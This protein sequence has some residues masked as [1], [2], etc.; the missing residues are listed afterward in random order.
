MNR[1]ALLMLTI[2]SIPGIEASHQVSI[3]IFLLSSLCLPVQL[4][5]LLAEKSTERTPPTQSPEPSQLS[6][7]T[8]SVSAL[9]H[10]HLFSAEQEGIQALES[11]GF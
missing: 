9:L 1:V 8:V 11:L 3:I 2:P 5:D 6:W 7:A 4:K 10:H